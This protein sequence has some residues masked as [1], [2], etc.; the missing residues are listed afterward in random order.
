MNGPCPG[1][2]LFTSDGGRTWADSGMA[3]ERFAATGS[4]AW[5]VRDNTHAGAGGGFLARTDDA[6]AT[7][8]NLWQPTA[9]VIRHFQ[10]L[11]AQTGWM[12]TNVGL[13]KTTDGGE[14]WASSTVRLPT[15]TVSS[16]N[17]EPFFVSETTAFTFGPATATSA[18]WDLMRSDDSG[19]TWRAVAL[20]VTRTGDGAADLRVGWV[21]FAD[22]QH[23]WV[24][25]PTRC[26]DTRR[27]PDVLLATTDC[28][29]TWIAL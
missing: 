14:H 29:A 7:W 11:D 5:I 12:D 28:G 25:L 8:L 9:L 15:S 27:C 23:G 6:G 3:V 13:F 4:R 2:L 21:T 22:P 16:P 20:P 10:F 17:A 19:Q 18:D 24:S 1:P 26:R